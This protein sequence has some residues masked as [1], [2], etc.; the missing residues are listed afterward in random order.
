MSAHIREASGPDR[1]PAAGRVFDLAAELPGP[2]D[3]GE[4]AL[5]TQVDEL[6]KR[7]AALVANGWEMP[8]ADL[9]QV[10]GLIPE[11]T[12]SAR[13]GAALGFVFL[14]LREYAAMR[15]LYAELARVH[16]PLPP[17]LFFQSLAEDRLER[18]EE[19]LDLAQR[20]IASGVR[21]YWVFLHAARLSRRLG[22]F[23]DSV[24]AANLAVYENAGGET[25]AFVLLAEN[26]QA[27]GELNRMLECFSRIEEMKGPAALEALGPLYA[28]H[29]VMYAQ[30]KAMLRGA[31]R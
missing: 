24:A 16:G 14:M 27:L 18:P 9:P 5:I 12:G 20:V 6:A 11:V 28:D 31:G 17:L 3:D 8:E 2:A 26:F 7:V 10:L 22:R 30:V 23:Q 29:R 25:E 21:N 13:A 4:A 1:D 15:D 19:A